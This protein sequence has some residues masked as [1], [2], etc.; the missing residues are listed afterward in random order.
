V[1]RNKKYMTTHDVSEKPSAPIASTP[2]TGSDDARHAIE[3]LERLAAINATMSMHAMQ[4][5][6]IHGS[7]DFRREAAR[8]ATL[9]AEIGNRQNSQLCQPVNEV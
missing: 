9:I 5:G 1:A 3:S 7:G 6:D 4:R 8:C 2:R